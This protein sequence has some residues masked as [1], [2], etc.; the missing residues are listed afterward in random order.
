MS[1][2][3]SSPYELPIGRGLRLGLIIFALFVVATFV[4]YLVLG[5]LGTGDV[6]RIIVSLLLGPVTGGLIFWAWWARQSA[7]VS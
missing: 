6:A 3:P 5:L 2:P 7:P 1:T 4:F